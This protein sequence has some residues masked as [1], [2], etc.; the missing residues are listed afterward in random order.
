MGEA[1]NPSTRARKFRAAAA[2]LREAWKA[3]R[4]S[5]AER[6]DEVSRTK[7][8]AK[9]GYSREALRLNEVIANGFR[10]ERQLDAFIAQAEAKGWLAFPQL[11]RAILEVGDDRD[12]EALLQRVLAEKLT[13]REILHARSELPSWAGRRSWKGPK[14]RRRYTFSDPSEVQSKLAEALQTAARIL[15][16][17]RLRG[18]LPAKGDELEQA[19]DAAIDACLGDQRGSSS[20]RWGVD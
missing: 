2:A 16:D 10:T 12:R 13:F 8:V 11:T 18:M 5:G 19:I 3:G 4:R 7:Q 15:D 20:R 6:D 17:A 9:A 1:P 14:R